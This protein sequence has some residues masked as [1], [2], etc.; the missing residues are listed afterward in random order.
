MNTKS[1]KKFYAY[2]NN[3]GYLI[4]HQSEYVPDIQRIP[5]LDIEVEL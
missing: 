3:Q 2:L 1:K 5:S 4:W